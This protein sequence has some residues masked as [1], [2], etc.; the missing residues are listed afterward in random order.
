MDKS[1]FIRNN[2]K[3]NFLFN[4]NKQI[5]QE[6]ENSN[7]LSFIVVISLIQAVFFISF[8]NTVNFL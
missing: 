8:D 6:K 1:K 7:K 5:M 2:S 3:Y 4:F